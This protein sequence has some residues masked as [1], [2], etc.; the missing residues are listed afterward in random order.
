MEYG[1]YK[2]KTTFYNGRNLIR[3]NHAKHS[4]A[5]VVRAVD[6]MQTNHY[7]A[8]VAEVYDEQSGEL[9]AV[10]TRSISGMKIVFKREIEGDKGYGRHA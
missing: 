8:T 1:K 10:L 4:N 9:H 6:H 7:G 2:I 5:A 3:V